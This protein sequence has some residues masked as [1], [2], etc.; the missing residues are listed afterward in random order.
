[1]AKGIVFI[2]NQEIVLRF[3]ASGAFEALEASHELVFAFLQIDGM[4]P[5]NR[6]RSYFS[7]VETR[8]EWLPFYA[9]RQTRWKRLFDISCILYQDKSAS[10]QVRNQE[11]AL[12]DPGR[13]TRLE[14]LTKPDVFEKYIIDLRREMGLNPAILSIVKDEKPDFFLLPSAIYDNLTDDVLQIG[15]A[16]AIPTLML[17]A[18]WDNLSSKGLLHHFPTM[19]GVW[20]EQSMLHAS[21]VQGFDPAHIRLAGAPHY[22]NFRTTDAVDKRALRCSL[23]IPDE[24]QLVLFAGTFRLFDETQLLIDIETAIE[25]GELPPM[26]ILY[27]PHPYRTTRRH[28]DSF[29]DYQW[30]HITMDSQMVQAYEITRQNDQP[31]LPANFMERINYQVQ[32]YQAVDAVICPMSTVLLESMLF[33]LPIMAVAFGDGKHSW[34]ADKVSRMMHFS[35]L[36]EIPQV[37][38]CRRRETFFA[39]V[40]KLLSHIGDEQ[41][42]QALLQ[43][44]QALV[45]RD[46]RPY[47]ERV[48]ALVDEMLSQSR[49][50]AYDKIDAK[51]GRSYI[52][53]ER[54]Y[55]LR[56]FLARTA[57]QVLSDIGLK[58]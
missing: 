25:A 13:F 15:E 52:I 3:M 48:E 2:P 49:P 51:P 57:R 10:F 43:G 50:P 24:E 38:V 37:I 28:E 35:E 40:E 5:E 26:H 31:P 30:R 44:T 29:F 56:G 1:M 55:R 7:A 11:R 58:R 6:L 8:L 18:G 22:E 41:V 23:G 4:P 33:G 20:G 46:G 14:A 53:E 47:A 32:L 34:S 54:R 39:G 16:L 36:Y 17:V 42:E 21:D 19:M 45:Y 9:G 12:E 27:R